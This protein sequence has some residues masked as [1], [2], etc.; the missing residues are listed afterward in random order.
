MR[1]CSCITVDSVVRETLTAHYCNTSSKFTHG[2]P[3]ITVRQVEEYGPR[4]WSGL[5]Q[6]STNT[7]GFTQVQMSG[8]ETQTPEDRAP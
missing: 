8:V 3:F 2:R 7:L 5:T 1:I 6:K 4:L